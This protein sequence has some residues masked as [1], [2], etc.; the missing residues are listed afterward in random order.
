VT[1]RRTTLLA[2]LAAVVVAVLALGGAATAAG[3]GTFSGTLTPTSCG[4]LQDVQVVAGDTTID[5]VA[6]E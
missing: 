6:A 3:S 4:P 2:C 5:A 1:H